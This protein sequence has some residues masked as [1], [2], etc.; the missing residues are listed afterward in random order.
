MKEKEKLYVGID[1]HRKYSVLTVLDEKGYIQQ[2]KRIENKDTEG[3]KQVLLKEEAE[4]IAAVESTYG[5]YWMA[6]LCEELPNVDLRLGHTMGIKA[7]NSGGK[8]TDKIDSKLLADLVRC[9][10]YPESHK[11]TKYHRNIKDILRHRTHLVEQRSGLKRRLHAMLAKINMECEYSDILGVKSKKWLKENVKKYP[12]NLEVK[13]TLNISESIDEEIKLM[14]KELEE[15]A[16]SHPDI[17]LI[18]T[19]P[20][21]GLISGLTIL[22]EID[23]ITRFDHPRKLCSYAGLVPNV[24]S[25]GGKT[26]MGQTKEGNKYIRTMLAETFYHTIK[27]DAFLRNKYEELKEKKGSNKAKV[28]IMRKILTNIY[29]VLT[30]R[31]PYKY[32]TID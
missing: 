2:R 32:R 16:K 8:K 23:D 26:Y 17:E 6:D 3:L 22:S 14:D 18:T 7:L 9:N 11:T 30:K 20:G 19:T 27:K 31:E 4:V 25:S 24:K 28:A 10:L 15:V 5:W 29:F 21:I 13:T 12:Y 1:L